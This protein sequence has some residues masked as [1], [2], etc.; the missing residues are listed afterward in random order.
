MSKSTTSV[1][2]LLIC[3]YAYQVKTSTAKNRAG[4]TL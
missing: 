2:F 1:A 4:A 3:K